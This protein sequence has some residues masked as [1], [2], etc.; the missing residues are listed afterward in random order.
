[1]S[2]AAAVQRLVDFGLAHVDEIHA[3]NPDN[4]GEQYP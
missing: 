4:R 3:N 1:M 2:F